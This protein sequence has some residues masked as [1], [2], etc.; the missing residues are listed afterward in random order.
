MSIGRKIPAEESLARLQE[1]KATVVNGE[2]ALSPPPLPNDGETKTSQFTARVPKFTLEHIILSD[3][4]RQEVETL[5]SRIANHDL[6]YEQWEFS[7]VDPQGKNIAVNFYGL[8]GTGKTMLAEALAARLGKLIIEVNYAEIESKYV[9]DTAKNIVSS[10]QEAKKEG[11]VLFFDEADSILG[12]RLTNVTQSADHG[13]NVSR[14]V[15]LKQMD[16]F[17]GVVVFA[18][19]LAKNFDSAFVRR[20]LQHVQVLPPD[21]PGRKQIWLR[22]ISRPVPGHNQIDFDSLAKESEGLTGGQIKNAALLS[23]SRLASETDPKRGLT[24][25][26]VLLAIDN[27]RKA[28]RDVGDSQGEWKELAP[29]P[30]KL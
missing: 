3:A 22:M 15:M 1:G 14:S 8:P 18:T 7:K 29:T 11:A 6:I 4:V 17:A 9:G 24:N 2:K 5:L 10:F 21:F 30:I 12:R 27:I 26:S 23:L 20:I 13:V 28:Q 19:N 16:D 25:S